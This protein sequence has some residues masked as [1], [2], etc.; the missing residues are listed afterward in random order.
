MDREVTIDEGQGSVVGASASA[1]RSDEGSRFRVT[2]VRSSRS[3][4]V[5]VCRGCCCGTD[6]KHPGVD[7]RDQVERL[8][9][10]LPAGLPSRLWQ[11]DCP[12]PCSSSNVVVVRSGRSRRWFGEMLDTEDIDDLADWIRSGARGHPT[13]RVAGREFVPELSEGSRTGARSTRVARPG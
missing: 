13:A 12:G 6:A 10:A 1:R 3:F 5:L 8:G 11:V 9:A 2:A 4:S 7:H